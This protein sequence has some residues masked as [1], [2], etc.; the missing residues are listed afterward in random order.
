MKYTG[1]RAITAGLQADTF[2]E[3]FDVEKAKQEYGAL[4]AEREAH[5]AMVRPH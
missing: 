5:T 4:M 1:Y 3:A 2:L